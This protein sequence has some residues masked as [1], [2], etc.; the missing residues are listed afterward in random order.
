MGQIHAPFSTSPTSTAD[1]APDADPPRV[2]ETSAI[3][4]GGPG[5]TTSEEEEEEEEEEAS[6]ELE[7]RGRSAGE[8]DRRR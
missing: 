1:D 3:G 2:K 4:G 5:S 6:R 8:G 7:P